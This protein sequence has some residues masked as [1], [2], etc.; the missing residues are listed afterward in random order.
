MKN[1]LH[2][3]RNNMP[4]KALG[5]ASHVFENDVENIRTR[6]VKPITPIANNPLISEEAMSCVQS[7]ANATGLPLDCIVTEA[8]LYWWD[9][10]A[11]NTV[12]QLERCYMN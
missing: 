10:S 11:G 8:L 5:S 1:T 12:S 6:N 3:E 4:S 9:T 2:F 7:F